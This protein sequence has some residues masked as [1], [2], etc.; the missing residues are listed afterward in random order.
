MADV[1]SRSPVEGLTLALP[2]L[3]LRERPLAGLVQVAAWPDTVAALDAALVREGLPALPPPGRSASA[4]GASVM[5]VGPGRALIDAA[6]P[7]LFAALEASVPADIGTV[8]DLSHAR[9]CLSLEG[10]RAAWVLAKGVAVDLHPA[11][12]PA[13]AVAT[14]QIDHAGVV[15]R[16]TGA[17][18]FVLYPYTGFAASLVHWLEVA[19]GRDTL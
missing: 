15:L 9:V 1:L 11:A 6:R 8:T 17:D 12:F 19:G 4:G 5:D 7:D 3:A 10:P 14:T 13:G 16:R 2:D 18:A